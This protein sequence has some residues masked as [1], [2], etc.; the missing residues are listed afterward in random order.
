MVQ[1]IYYTD[2]RLD[3]KIQNEVCS[4]L[5][6]IKI[7]II[8]CSLKP[9][10]F[11]KNIVLDLKP[12]PETMLKQIIT[13]LEASSGYV[14]LCEHDVIYHPSHFIEHD[15]DKFYFNTN[16]WK[17]KWGTELMVWTDDLQQLSGMSGKKEVLLNHFKSIVDFNRHYEPKRNR[18][19]YMSELPNI[20]IRHGGNLTK[21][22]W[23]TEDFRNKKY[24]KGFKEG[25]IKDLWLKI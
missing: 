10:D 8:S 16:V 15:G 14:F 17:W 5:L 2:N 3:E 19:N 20:D 24:A 13:A 18:E 21:S 11:G 12:S 25:N 4:R 6:D 9:M 7:P 1:I 22:K 23:S